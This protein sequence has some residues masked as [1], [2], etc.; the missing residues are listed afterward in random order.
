[1]PAR[2][3]TKT[4]IFS[5]ALAWC[6][7]AVAICPVVF[8]WTAPPASPLATHIAIDLGY[9]AVAVL[10]W[11]IY[12]TESRSLGRIT[13]AAIVFLVFLLS[14]ITNRIHNSNVDRA[15]NYIAG[16][17]NEK[18]QE[19]LHASVTRLSPTD[20]PHSYRFL[21]NAIVL[22]MQLARV[23]FDVARDLYRQL[24]MLVLFYAIYRFARLY[25]NFIGGAIAMLLVCAVYP[26]SF[27]NYVGQLTDPLSHLSF[28]LAF[29][30]LA[31]GDFASLVTVLLIGSL[32]KETVLALAGFYAIFCR[33]DTNYL[34]KT[35]ALCAAGILIYVGVRLLVLHGALHYGQVSG[36]PPSHIVENWQDYKWHRSFLFTAGAY[37]P[38]L[39]FAWR[40]T[41][42]LLKQ[43]TF[44]LI[45]VLFVS[46]LVFGWLG[47]SRN[48]M[49]VVFV[50]AVVAARFLAEAGA[51][52]V[53]RDD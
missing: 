27:E 35:V 48:F 6:L 23:R 31:T 7:T 30:F 18:L 41:P 19:Q 34:I 53:I 4:R 21:P 5:L 9:L 45:P 51:V 49:P 2:Q 10:C 47:E 1:V 50:L 24:T 40:E 12:R 13:A 46:S 20:A 14:S 32:A 42:P 15:A 43:L 22:W 33:K 26:I 28:A 29:L 37:L 39:A 25:T 17:P 8:H 3:P 44:Y 16:V 11:F 38:F 52:S 36:A